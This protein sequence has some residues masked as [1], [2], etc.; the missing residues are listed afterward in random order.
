MSE[1]LIGYRCWLAENQ[2]GFGARG[3]LV[4][5]VSSFTDWTRGPLTAVCYGTTDSVLRHRIGRRKDPPLP[6][7]SCGIYAYDRLETAKLQ[8]RSYA[9]RGLSRHMILGAVLLWGRVL[10]EDVAGALGVVYRAQHAQILV[11]RREDP[12]A[13]AVAEAFS[14]PVVSERYLEAKAGEFG[15]HLE[16]AI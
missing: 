2:Y 6:K 15:H 11:I 13:E 5:S 7:C 4:R 3:L 14:I 16:P 12:L 9:E 10:L 1:A 8:M